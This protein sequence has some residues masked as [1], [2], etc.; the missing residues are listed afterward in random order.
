MFTAGGWDLVFY[1][2]LTMYIIPLVIQC[3]LGVYILMVQIKG[4]LYSFLVLSVIGHGIFTVF[5][6]Y[7]HFRLSELVI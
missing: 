1:M 7:I 5:Y 2:N 3:F 6:E 4:I